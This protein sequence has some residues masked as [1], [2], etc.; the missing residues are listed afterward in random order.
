VEEVGD[1]EG[2]EVFRFD[3]DG[4]FGYQIF[5]TAFGLHVAS[6]EPF[7]K[8]QKATVLEMAAKSANEMFWLGDMRP[9]DFEHCAS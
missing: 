7:I 4:I 8:K 9:E 1:L 3:G 5:R 6:S 2:S